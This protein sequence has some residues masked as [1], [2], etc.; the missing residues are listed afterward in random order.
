MTIQ[1]SRSGPIPFPLQYIDSMSQHRKT[2]QILN[3]DPM[4]FSRKRLCW[5]QPKI[6]S[7]GFSLNRRLSVACHN[8]PTWVVFEYCIKIPEYLWTRFRKEI[9]FYIF[10]IPGFVLHCRNSMFFYLIGNFLYENSLSFLPSRLSILWYVTI[11]LQE[12]EAPVIQID[13]TGEGD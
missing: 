1:V 6:F 12:P 5:L 3:C 13:D 11:Q 4:S 2:V 8:L 7:A 10:V 9:D